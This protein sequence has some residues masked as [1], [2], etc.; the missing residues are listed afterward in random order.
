MSEVACLRGPG[1]GSLLE[2]PG[3]FAFEI[4]APRRTG[5]R[6]YSLVR[7]GGEAETV[8]VSV[9]G[10]LTVPFTLAKARVAVGK[11]Q[12]VEVDGLAPGERVKVK[13][14]GAQVD[15]GHADRAGRF[16]SR[17]TVTGESGRATVKVVGQFADR[18]NRQGF[19]VR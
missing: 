10:D 2:G 8:Q 9:L 18:T 19:Q 17:F 11:R 16:V 6:T 1:A 7:L 15:S 5:V 12:V 4:P 14:R 13:F 3:S